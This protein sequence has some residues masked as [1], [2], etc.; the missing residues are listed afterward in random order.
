[1]NG[2]ILFISKIEICVAMG[3]GAF[4]AITGKLRKL[5]ATVLIFE[6]ISNIV[7]VI[8]AVIHVRSVSD[9]WSE[10]WKY[11]RE[12]FSKPFGPIDYTEFNIQIDE[13]EAEN[14]ALKESNKELEERWLAKKIKKS[15]S[16]KQTELGKTVKE[17]MEELN[18]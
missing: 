17:K 12:N 8:W 7:S 4:S 16:V 2:W 14:K 6:M 11:F 9:S 1:M 15:R 13:L 3:L 5:V 10:T 18:L